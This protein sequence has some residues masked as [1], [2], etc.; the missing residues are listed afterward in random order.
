[1]G[2]KS[3]FF[4]SKI[5]SFVGIKKEQGNRTKRLKRDLEQGNRTKIFLICTFD[6]FCKEY[7]EK[8]VDIL[9]HKI[10]KNEHLCW[11]FVWK[12]PP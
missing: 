3:F 7:V 5:V 8:F 4:G 6:N 2:F 10:K 11:S 1:M 9:K 12:N